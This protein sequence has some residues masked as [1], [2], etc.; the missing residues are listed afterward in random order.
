MALFVTQ[1]L[2]RMQQLQDHVERVVFVLDGDSHPMKKE[3]HSHRD[4][5]SRQ[6]FNKA[7]AE[8]KRLGGNVEDSQVFRTNAKKWPRFTAAT[9]AAIV[10][11]RNI[12]DI[13]T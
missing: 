4:R 10:E 6:A 11:V 8:Y 9:K 13:L 3:T 1:A 5:Q 12:N 7:E 2:D